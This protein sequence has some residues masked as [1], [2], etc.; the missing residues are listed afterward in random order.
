MMSIMSRLFRRKH[1]K[2]R[3]GEI[4]G[5]GTEVKSRVWRPRDPLFG[6]KGDAVDDW[7]LIGS[8]RYAAYDKG[9]HS[10]ILVSMIFYKSSKHGV[11]A[12]IDLYYP[13]ELDYKHFFYKADSACGVEVGPADINKWFEYNVG[14]M[15]GIFPLTIETFDALLSQNSGLRDK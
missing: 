9:K 11:V 2:S 5:S 13:M 3:Q 1:G 8:H 10:L 15:V 14:R 7:E 12:K 4:T 6:R